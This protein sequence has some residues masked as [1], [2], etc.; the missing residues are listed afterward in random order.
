M[1]VWSN[2]VYKHVVVHSHSFT[3]AFQCVVFR[4]CLNILITLPLMYKGTNYFSAVV[5]SRSQRHQR[6][7]NV[8]N[9][10]CQVRVVE[11]HDLNEITE[12]HTQDLWEKDA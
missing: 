4:Y 10:C 9:R 1:G 8:I 5:I 7:R 2:V 11:Q 6:A 3:Q 12:A